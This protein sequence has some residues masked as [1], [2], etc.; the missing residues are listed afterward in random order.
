VNKNKLFF[1]QEELSSPEQ[2]SEVSTIDILVLDGRGADAERKILDDALHKPIVGQAAQEIANLF[3]QL[4]SGS[5]ARCH[6]P[7]FGLRFYTVDGLQ[8]QCSICW[9]CNNICGDFQY[10]FD[11]D[12]YISQELFALLTQLS[13]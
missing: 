12:N 10:D 7:P 2:L 11:A 9:E 3:R 13:K 8:R 6:T 1:R 4:P 5:S